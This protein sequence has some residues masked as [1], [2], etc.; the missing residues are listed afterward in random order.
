MSFTQLGLA[1]NLLETIEKKGY[2]QATPI[3]EQAIPIILEGNDILGKAQ[4]GTGKTAA[5]ALPIIQLLAERSS[6]DRRFPRS[7][8]ITPTREL[9][10]Q[11]AQSFETYGSNSSLKYAVLYGGV[12][13]NPQIDKLKRGVDILVATPGRLLDLYRQNHVVLSNVEILVLDEADRMLDMGFIDDI[14]QIVQA[15][16]RKRQSLL[17][18]ATYG[19][20]IL[21]LAQKFLYKPVH[22]EI[23][24]KTEAAQTVS[25][26]IYKTNSKAK[27]GVVHHLICQ[28]K[29]H[30]V[31]IFTRTKYGANRLADYL[32]KHQVPAAAIHGNKSQNARN[33]ALNAF[34][35]GQIVALVATDVAARGLDINDISHVVNFELPQ[36]AEDY[37]HRIGRTGRAGS[38]GAAISLI[39]PEEKSQLKQIERFTRQ[40]IPTGELKG[41]KGETISPD[42][43]IVE[44][45]MG[46]RRTSNKPFTSRP[47]RSSSQRSQ[48]NPSSSNRRFS[49]KKRSAQAS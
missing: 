30:R 25:Q 38:T 32:G 12:G 14:R 3:Q 28:G 34:K 7:L 41:E 11:V 2:S 48:G 40:R 33:N 27:R 24:S 6:E 49:N 20:A 37:V 31:L 9:A 13:L 4:T 19:R 10:Q 23:A 29:W 21:N 16:P 5:F 36:V 39:S 46:P 15:V 22:V 44:S 26:I 8:I 17:F 43:F 35:T 1:A 18:S 45:A 47:K 42:T